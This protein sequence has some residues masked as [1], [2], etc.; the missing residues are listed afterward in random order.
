MH[1]RHH[2]PEKELP[3]CLDSASLDF[4]C[5]LQLQN[6][7]G[8][9]SASSVIVERAKSFPQETVKTYEKKEGKEEE[10]NRG[11]DCPEWAWKD[12][13][14]C[15]ILWYFEY[16]IQGFPFGVLF[17]ESLVKIWIVLSFLQR[18]FFW[19]CSDGSASGPCLHR[20]KWKSL[21]I[22]LNHLDNIYPNVY[23]RN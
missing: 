3:L 13:S 10:R 19:M 8:P 5:I 23:Q 20:L 17:V 6:W 14:I 4:L 11:R 22:I 21:R 9:S 7:I 15:K 1:E 18:S 12:R 2:F 16:V